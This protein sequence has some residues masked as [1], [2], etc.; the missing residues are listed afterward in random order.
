MRERD[1]VLLYQE[2][3]TDTAT[4]TL[5]LDLPDPISALDIEVTCTN[6]ATSNLDNFI[7][8]IV[9]KIEVVDGSDVIVSLNM[10]ELEALQFYKTGKPPVLFPSE[11]AGGGQRH[12]A[13]LLFGRYLYDPDFGFNPV[14]YRN[15]QLKITFNKAAVRAA[16]A[17]GFAS[18]NNIILS[19][20]AKVMEQGPTPGFVLMQ[21]EIKSFTSAASGDERVELPVD[22]PYRLMLLRPWVSGSDVDEVI[23]N[24]KLTVDTDKFIPFDRKVKQLDAEAFAAFGPFD[25]KH[26]MYR[27]GS[28]TAIVFANKEPHYT[29]YV[30]N[31]GTPRVLVPYAQ[32][33]S[34]YNAELYDMA[35]AL[36]GTSRQ[37]TGRVHG[38]A[39]HATLPVVFGK[40]MEPDTWF[41]VSGYGKIEA[42]LT[43]GVASA[44]VQIALEQ[45]RPQ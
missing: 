11:W 26:D 44:T 43:Q 41:P 2:T 17:T 37:I 3:E 14:K 1:A 4:K 33:S 16:S 45:V 9:T 34:N 15:P 5:D 12:E 39:L 10:F 40:L 32:W 22:Y 42:V 36:D 29:G 23:S 25:Y 30:R 35:G 8:D 6:G 28:F 13:R 38:H 7:S 19:V 20:I 31:P 27:G 24:L 18:G 21:K